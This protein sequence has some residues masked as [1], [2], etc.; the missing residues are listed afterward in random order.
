MLA[1]LP[2]PLPDCTPAP[3]PHPSHASSPNTPLLIPAFFLSPRHSQA[4]GPA[5]SLSDHSLTSPTPPPL[6]PAFFS[7]PQPSLASFGNPSPWPLARIYCITPVPPRSFLPSR[8]LNRPWPS[9]WPLAS[10]GNPSSSG[11]HWLCTSLLNC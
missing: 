2:W 3:P 8:L 7:S 10:F 9:P 5:L 11:T 4:Q 6:V 1:D